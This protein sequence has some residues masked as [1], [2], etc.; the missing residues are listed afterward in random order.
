MK[1]C[2]LLTPS[3]HS[4]LDVPEMTTPPEDAA[5][6]CELKACYIAHS[7]KEQWFKADILDCKRLILL[8]Y[9]AYINVWGT[10]I[11]F[12]SSDQSQTIKAW[13]IS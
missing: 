8:P 7:N 10:L 2:T 11:C 1:R 9:I 3:D 5:S 6:Y 13:V 12:L 4:L